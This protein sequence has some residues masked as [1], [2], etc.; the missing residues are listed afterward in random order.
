MD[1]DKYQYDSHRTPWRIGL[2]AC[3]NN[4]ARARSYVTLTSNFFADAS[5]QE[6]LGALADMYYTTGGKFGTKAN[7]MSLIG[8][9]AAS[10]MATTRGTAAHKAF[11]D[12]GY[13]FLVDAMY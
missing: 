3:W 6:G 11:L 2:D 7:S 12:R 13:R 8:T 1:A 9:A 4:E 10:A 5:D